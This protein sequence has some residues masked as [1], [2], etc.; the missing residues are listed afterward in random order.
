MF[1]D[2]PHGAFVAI[3]CV[4]MSRL[5]PHPRDTPKV[6]RVFD[7]HAM[8]LR[9]SMDGC[10]RFDRGAEAKAAGPGPCPL[11]SLASHQ[12]R[13]EAEVAFPVP[14][15]YPTA[16][17]LIR[18]IIF[19]SSP[20]TYLWRLRGVRQQTSTLWSGTLT[21]TRTQRAITRTAVPSQ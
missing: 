17:R 8:A 6:I 5:I 1:R 2:G 21:D 16:R 11:A 9:R 12:Q 14:L 7:L 20:D 13:L 10:A 15:T 3:P 4:A 18:V 19:M